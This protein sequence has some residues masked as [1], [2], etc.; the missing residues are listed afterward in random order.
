MKALIAAAAIEKGVTQ[1]GE[2]HNCE[3]GKLM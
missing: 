2:I 3:N 1:P